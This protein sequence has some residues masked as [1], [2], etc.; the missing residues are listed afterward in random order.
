MTAKR[1]RLPS[2]AQRKAVAKYDRESVDRVLL[3]LPKGQKAI[4]AEHIQNTS[5]NSL[6]SFIKRAIN[7][8]LERDN[9][10]S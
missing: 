4:I 6:N 8:T 2:D 3:R 1:K 10:N 5:D 9:T 7:E